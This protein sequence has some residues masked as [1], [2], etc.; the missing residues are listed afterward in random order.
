MPSASLVAW[1]PLPL[2]VLRRAASQCYQK[3]ATDATIRHIIEA[4][5]LSVLEHVSVTFEIT[6][7]LTVLLQ[8]TRHRHLS[9]TV[10]SSRGTLLDDLH[11][12]GILQVDAQ[13]RGALH[14]YHQLASE[15]YRKD[16]LAYIL[17]KGITYH[18]VATGNFRAWYEYLPKR[19]CQRATTEHRE[20]A[21]LLQH[22]LV[23]LCPEVFGR[24]SAPCSHCHE[25]SCAFHD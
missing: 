21:E 8:L 2:R 1:T 10:Q 25:R 17:P 3:E 24:I 13:N 16:D 6:C 14:R 5:H 12:T 4:G 18:L 19:L 11:E 7:S 22:H 23:D 15:G 20:L 9:F